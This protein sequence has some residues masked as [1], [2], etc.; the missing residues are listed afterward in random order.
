MTLKTTLAVAAVGF[1]AATSFAQAETAR[2]YVS[3]GAGLNILEDTNISGGGS[4]AGV[5]FNNGWALLGAAGVGVFDN[6]RVEAELAHRHNSVD[7]FSGDVSSNSLMANALYD[8]PF[9]LGIFKPYVGVG[10]GGARVKADNI[11]LGGVFGNLNDSDSTWAYQG[12]AG[13]SAPI[14]DNLSFL[15]DYRYFST[16]QDIEMRTSTGVKGSGEYDNHTI[17]VGLRW[18]FGGAAAAAPMAQPVAAPQPAPPPAPVA[19]A[20]PLVRSFLVFFDFDK[21]D[22]TDDARKIIVQAAEN[23]KKTG[24]TTRITLTG[25]AD[26]SGSAQYNMRLS[27]RRADAVKAELVKL[28]VGANDIATIAKG[29]SDPLV[30]TADGVREPRNRR[31]EIVF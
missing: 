11:G 28:G 21:S 20:A 9:A 17:M 22:I 8:I 26:R 27:Q 12:I 18:S 1:L 24:G 16:F 6:V 4:S 5:N 30:P 14:T 13:L 19:A 2:P 15:L 29:E 31:V 25:H 10:L 23:A 3:L 7:N